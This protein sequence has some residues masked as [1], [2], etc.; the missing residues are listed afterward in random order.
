MKRLSGL[1]VTA[2]LSVA[3]Y[4]MLTWGYDAWLALTSPTYGLDDAW[5]SQSTFG[6][7][8]YLGLTPDGLIR[9]AAVIAALKITVAGVC[10]LHLVDR[11][12][13]LMFGTA[14]NEVIEAGLVLAI[15]LSVVLA[16]PVILNHNTAVLREHITDIALATIAIALAMMER[17]R[18]EQADAR[19]IIPAALAAAKPGWYSPLR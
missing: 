14:S 1:G 4:F 16:L 18:R 12:R 3:L 17:T 2:I 13:M 10:A 6:L 19:P 9:L 8:R 7:G 11:A 15:S 5:R